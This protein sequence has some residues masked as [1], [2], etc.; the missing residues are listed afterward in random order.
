MLP[1]TRFRQTAR[2]CA[3]SLALASFAALAQPPPP[4]LPQPALTALPAT[5]QAALREL[6]GE[7]DRNIGGL[8]GEQRA[9]AYL[10]I[11]ALYLRSGLTEAA[12][13]ALDH[14]VAAQPSDPRFVYLRGVAAMWQKQASGAAAAF[15]RTITL[16]PNY[17]PAH[18]HLAE[19]QISTNDLVGARAT[20]EKLLAKRRDLAPALA[21]MGEIALREERYADSV[22]RFTEALTLEPQADALYARLA[23]AHAGLGDEAAAAEAQAKAGS[24][25]PRIADPLALELNG[26]GARSAPAASPA[27][28]AS[29]AGLRSSLE[30][31]V[32]ASPRDL[33][34][35]LALVEYLALAGDLEAARG[36]ARTA[37]AQAPG[38]ADVL[39]AQAIVAEASGDDAGSRTLLQRAVAANPKHTG[40]RLR[41]ADALLRARQVDGAYTAYLAAAGPAGD[42]Q[43]LASAVA[44]A[45][46][47]NR[48]AD[49]L[50]VLRQTASRRPNDG[51][52]AQIEVRAIS[53]CPLATAAQKTQALSVAQALYRQNPDGELAEALAMALAANGRGA[54]AVGYEAEAIFDATK[55]GDTPSL[56]GRRQWVKQF[57][58]K[59]AVSRPWPA[60]N[61][62]FA[63]PALR[64]AAGTPTAAPA[65]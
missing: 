24:V 48:C 62:L 26:P 51:R 14:A 15:A 35:R 29:N 33:P 8:R 23:E 47:A 32:S 18:Y 54:D 55:R 46:L 30:Q 57:E 34:S 7:F 60:G 20:L 42:A 9:I 44:A 37:E 64:A 31:K 10:Q 61:L 6:R 5:Q 43:A 36:H 40:A 12:N 59:Q 58:G 25:L 22:A 65:R 63:P 56:A 39:L 52:L 21:M 53:S 28:A 13:I 17:L 2:A 11:G 38:N 27:A 4:P 49:V 45:S 19:I 1:V 41:Y 50:P 3:L 16:D